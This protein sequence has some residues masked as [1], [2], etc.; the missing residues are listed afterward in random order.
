MLL[1]RL[2]IIDSTCLLTKLKP[3]FLV[4]NIIISITINFISNILIPTFILVSVSVL[5]YVC[6]API[7]NYVGAVVDF[8]VFYV[9]LAPIVTFEGAAID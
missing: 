2:L 6:V 3:K 9:L 4:E 1:E 5:L 8:V 7:V